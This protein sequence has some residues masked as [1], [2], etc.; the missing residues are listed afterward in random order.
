[1]PIIN[2]VNVA[3]SINADTTA[4]LALAT[5]IDA[6]TALL[7]NAGA[8][9]DIAN[10][11][12]KI[13]GAATDGLAGTNNSLAY[14]VHEIEKHAHSRG[15]F[16]G[17]VAVP[18]ET[19]AIEANVNRPFAATSGAN[20]WGAAIPIC[21]TDDM[22]VPTGEVKHDA[23]RFLISD[24]DNDT[25]PWRVRL[26]YGTGTSAAAIGAEQ[27][28][29]E[30]IESNAVPGNRAGGTPLDFQMPR[31]DVGTKLWAQVWNDTNNEVMSFFWGAHGYA[32]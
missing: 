31:I 14:R 4:T 1:M 17:A 25:T 23:H 7:P 19:N 8:L 9:T 32:G 30:M 6:V 15:R 28:S 16:W 21:G 29:E 20:T 24:L 11:T 2:G 26:I 18:D 10:E 5:A 3:T 27:W 22:P 12:E 13:D